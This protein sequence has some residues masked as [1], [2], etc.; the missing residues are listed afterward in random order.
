MFY[1]SKSFVVTL[2][3]VIDPVSREGNDEH[4]R[5]LA[6]GGRESQEGAGDLG[7]TGEDPGTG[8]GG[9]ESVTQFLYFRDTAGPPLQGGDLGPH[10]EDGGC[11]G[12]VPGQGSTA[13]EGT[14]ATP[15]EGRK[16]AVPPPVGSYQGSG[17]SASADIGTPETEYGRA[18]HCDATDS[19]T[20]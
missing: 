17:D 18:I 3:K 6:S 2:F 19:G 8:G 13:A 10:Q 14:H 12:R 20:L 1:F 7:E 15:W 4:R 16:V 11:P 9:P 5:R